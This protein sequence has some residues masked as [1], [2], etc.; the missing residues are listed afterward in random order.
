MKKLLFDGEKAFK[1]LEKMAVDI[2]TRPS[3]SEVEREAAKWIA[4]EFE[5][6]GLETSI[7]EFE[8]TSGKVV[9]QKLQVLEPF[10]EEVPCE[11]MPLYGSTGPGTSCT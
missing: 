3:G 6:L 4:S 9:N 10:N 5:A 2:G 1:Y 11:V 7:E 8:V